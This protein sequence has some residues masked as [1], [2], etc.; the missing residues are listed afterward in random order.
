MNVMTISLEELFAKAHTT[1]WIYEQDLDE[2]LSEEERRKFI[3][4]Y[5][6]LEQAN[7]AKFRL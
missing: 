5:V 2:P 3:E 6:K 4:D 7:A 1:L